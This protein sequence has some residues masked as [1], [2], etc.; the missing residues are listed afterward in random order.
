MLVEHKNVLITLSQTSPFFSKP[1]R[2]QHKSSHQNSRA[3][4]QR[5]TRKK[6]D[7]TAGTARKT[8]KYLKKKS[9]QWIFYG[10]DGKFSAIL[11]RGVWLGVNFTTWKLLLNKKKRHKNVCW[12]KSFRM[13]NDSATE[14]EKETILSPTQARVRTQATTKSHAHTQNEPI[15]SVFHEPRAFCLLVVGKMFGRVVLAPIFHRHAF[16]WL[17]L[18]F[19]HVSSTLQH[20]R[21]STD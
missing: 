18:Y 2:N 10:T 4:R 7:E 16:L 9:P 21:T 20:W 5:R 15:F 14:V 12:D 6:I 11:H 19:L 17:Y 8:R 3:R 13:E 1:F